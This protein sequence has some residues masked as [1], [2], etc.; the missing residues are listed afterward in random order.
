MSKE[1]MLEPARKF[2]EYLILRGRS[3]GTAYQN[4]RYI[5]QFLTWLGKKPEEITRDDIMNYVMYLRDG[6]GYSEGTVKNRCHAISSFLKFIGKDDLA[7]WVPIPSPKGREVEWLPE[8]IVLRVVDRDP[9]L[10][11]AYELALRVSEL[12]MLKRSEYNP[13]TGE[14]V[15]YREKH[16]GKPNRY[17]LKLSDEAREILNEYISEKRCPGDR[18]FCISRRAIQDRFKR[19]LRRAGLDPSRYSFHTLRHSRC[20]NIVIKYMREGKPVDLITLAK[21]MGH[22]DPRTTMMYI[23]IASRALGMETPTVVM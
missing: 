8:D 18:V 7:K 17:V 13:R 15:V 4:A 14:I 1:W 5:H 6:L 11:V 19:A 2:Y 12:L 10:R 3:P 22:L 16:K 20:T 23:H 21:F 9:Y